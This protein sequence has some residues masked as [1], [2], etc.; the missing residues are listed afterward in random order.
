[1]LVVLNASARR[2]NHVKN[3]LKQLAKP[4]PQEAYNSTGSGWDLKIGILNKFPGDAECLR[5]IRAT[6]VRENV[7]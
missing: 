7:L 6:E 3:L 1:M 5:T 4:H 2:Q